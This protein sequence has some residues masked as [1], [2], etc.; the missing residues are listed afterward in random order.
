MAETYKKLSQ[1]QVAASTANIHTGISTGTTIIRH[2]RFVNTHN[3]TL[4]L[5]LHHD[6]TAD[7]NQI[8]PPTNIAAGGWAEFD[9]VVIM[10]ASD[11]LKASTGT[12]DKITYTIYG[13]ELT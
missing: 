1:G 7:T 8:L 3:A 12:A 5:T 2:M 11:T 9:G 6:G 13:L 4:A 10:E